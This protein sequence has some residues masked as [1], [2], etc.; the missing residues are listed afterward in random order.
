[1]I[2]KLI[3][4]YEYLRCCSQIWQWCWRLCLW[5]RYGWMLSY[6]WVYS[7]LYGWWWPPPCSPED[8]LSPPSRTAPISLHDAGLEKVSLCHLST[9]WFVAESPESACTSHFWS[10]K[11]SR[12]QWALQ[13][14]QKQNVVIVSEESD[15][16]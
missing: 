6:L 4:I 10:W 12:Q 15:W 3:M 5:W 8:R 7:R 13:M 16:L 1:M 2:G 9:V 11:P 14:A